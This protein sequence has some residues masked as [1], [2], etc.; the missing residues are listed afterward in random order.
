MFAINSSSNDAWVIGSG[1]THHMCNNRDLILPYTI[2]KA[3]FTIR[4]DNKT[5]VEA[6]K[7]GIVIINAVQIKAL[8]VPRFQVSLLSVS[9]LDAK[10]GWSTSF[11][12]GKCTIVD[13]RGTAILRTTCVR[14]IYHVTM[15]RTVAGNLGAVVSPSDHSSSHGGS[16]TTAALSADKQRPQSAIGHKVSLATWHQRPAVVKL[17]TAG[18]SGVASAHAGDPSSPC[19]ICVKAK[20]RQ[21]IYRQP[22]ARCQVPF[23][24]VLLRGGTGCFSFPFINPCYH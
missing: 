22:V 24:L 16:D 21:R 1:A 14:G 12:D 18:G 2:T 9:K 19:T 13:A 5:T 15:P 4:L 10:L 7:E 8:F 23:E 6:V 3:N 17:L 20:M 11:A